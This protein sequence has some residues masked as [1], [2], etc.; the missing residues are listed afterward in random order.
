ML[1]RLVWYCHDRIWRISRLS[2]SDEQTTM[3][4]GGGWSAAI[5]ETGEGLLGAVAGS[6]VVGAGAC[7]TRVGTMRAIGRESV[8]VEFH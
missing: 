3:H 7:G 6:G 5:D 8:L 4:D 2:W 1:S